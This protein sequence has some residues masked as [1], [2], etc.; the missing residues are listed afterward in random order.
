KA[1]KYLFSFSSGDY[2]YEV[3]KGISENPSVEKVEG[4]IVLDHPV[5]G[6]AMPGNRLVIADYHVGKYSVWEYDIRE[7]TAKPIGFVEPQDNYPG[8]LAGD[9][10]YNPAQNEMF[11]LRSGYS[12][13]SI[14]VMRV[15]GIDEAEYE[16]VP[17]EFRHLKDDPYEWEPFYE[18]SGEL[19]T[20]FLEPRGIAVDSE[21]NAV[22]A[23]AKQNRVVEVSR[24]EIDERIDRFD[25]P[26][27]RI[28]DVDSDSFM[29]EYNTLRRVPT[30][31]EYGQLNGQLVFGQAIDPEDFT[32]VYIEKKPKK[33][34][35][36]EIVDLFPGTRYVY[37]FVAS[38]RDSPKYGF[39][40]LI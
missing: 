37:R 28:V 35:R 21:G 14:N 32:E 18:T 30:M 23:L 5:R 16:K 6:T 17:E 24:H 3:L 20:R 25:P 33:R 4:S 31:F 7:K 13:D 26:A 8:Y 9:V 27:M 38:D 22:V 29:I 40:L 10:A 11:Y 39:Q 12:L 1:G 34:H 15:S 19:K 36:V 2:S